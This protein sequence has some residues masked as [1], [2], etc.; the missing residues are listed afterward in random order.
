MKQTRLGHRLAPLLWGAFALT[1]TAGAAPATQLHGV[2][3]SP[4]T[5]TAG[6][7]VVITIIL[8]QPGAHVTL[9]TLGDTDALHIPAQPIPIFDAPSWTKEYTTSHFTDQSRSVQIRADFGGRSRDVLLHVLPAGMDPDPSPPDPPST[10]DT[11]HVIDS[12][13]EVSDLVRYAE[14]RGFRFRSS[15]LPGNTGECALSL[16][17]RV[18]LAPKS[19][20]WPVMAPPPRC[21]VIYFEGSR[22]ADGWTLKEAYFEGGPG[23]YGREHGITWKWIKSPGMQHGEGDANFAILTEEAVPHDYLDLVKV[24]LRGPAGRDWRPAFDDAGR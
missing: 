3:V 19:P 6:D 16:S 10:G 5:V 9:R 21:Q 14:Q 2:D 18:R 12:P 24:V 8:D 7:S 13:Q 1:L 4:K 20:I 11:E 22:L 15:V 23:A 17:P